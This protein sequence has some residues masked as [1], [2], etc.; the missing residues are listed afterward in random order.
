FSDIFF[1]HNLFSIPIPFVQ[2]EITKAQHI[3]TPQSNTT[4]SRS[5]CDLLG[6]FVSET[7][8]SP[9]QW[10]CQTCINLIFQLVACNM[11]KHH[12]CNRH[13]CGGIGLPLSEMAPQR[14]GAALDFAHSPRVNTQGITIYQGTPSSGAGRINF[15]GYAG[16]RYR[17]I[18][19]D[20]CSKG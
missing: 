7:P 5:V 3:C 2:Q 9:A 16:Y 11:P 12:G 19:S 10:C 17:S 15:S 18:A 20:A 4:S 8:S 6:I 1:W 13:G 14:L